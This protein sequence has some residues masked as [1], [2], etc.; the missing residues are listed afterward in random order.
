M[1]MTPNELAARARE[2]G[3]RMDQLSALSAVCNDDDLPTIIGRDDV[4]DE[5]R[6][7]WIVT[8]EY[9]GETAQAT[10]GNRFTAERLATDA[11]RAKVASKRTPDTDHDFNEVE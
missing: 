10:H 11:V 7:I 1:N 6:H 9:K 3:A 8:V 2:L 5:D 4:G